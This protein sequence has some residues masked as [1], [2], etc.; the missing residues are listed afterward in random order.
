MSS[1]R[2]GS[3]A[4]SATAGRA[5]GTAASD[6]ATATPLTAAAREIVTLSNLF[7]HGT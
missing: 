1:P 5:P 6:S 4:A 2:T 7:T 3:P